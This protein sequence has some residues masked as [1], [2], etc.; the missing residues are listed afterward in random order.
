MRSLNIAIIGAGWAGLTAGI[1]LAKSGA[2]T[3]IFEASHTLGGRARKVTFNNLTIDN[4]IHL[5]SGAYSAT[6]S[7][8]KQVSA[9]A[10]RANFDR[11]PFTYTYGALTISKPR[12]PLPAEKVFSF[13]F[14]RGISISEKLIAL[15][16]LRR[17][18]IGKVIPESSENVHDLLTRYR[19]SKKL[20]ELL[21]NPICLS[22]LNTDCTRG[23]ALIFLNVISDALLGSNK[24]SDL[25][26]PTTDL[27]SLFP[28]LA[29]RYILQH[30][31]TIHLGQ[32]ALITHT[33]NN[34]FQLSN[35]DEE[36]THIVVATAPHNVRNTFQDPSAIKNTLSI[37]DQFTYEPIYTIY[38]Q[39]TQ[40]ISTDHRMVGLNSPYAH[41]VFDRGLTHNEPGLIGV[42][43]SGSGRHQNM[44]HEELSKRSA[45][46]LDEK[47][48]FG[49]PLWSKVFAEK[50]ATFTCSPQLKRPKQI[51]DVNGIILAGDYTYSRYPAV[52]EAAVR[53][54]I[55]AS[56]II[57]G[58]P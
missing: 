24:S 44:T 39:Y 31:G 25:I 2:R 43:V 30:Q 4:G 55:E 15:K 9:S 34:R 11:Q 29:E 33:S 23:C 28:S 53:S 54:G 56:K 49:H 36:F 19:Q 3:A 7:I 50:R 27:T 57:L 37:I 10:D 42:V 52:L 8:L 17:I 14:A 26:F 12:V 1:K 48:G 38:H 21:W 32:R 13:L 45:K 58:Q 40:K 22:A 46:A 51:T 47:Y 41:W 6:L 20:I 5:L 35:S 18:Q 16:F